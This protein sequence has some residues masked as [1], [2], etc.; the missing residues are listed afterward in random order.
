MK[1]S[2]VLE[3]SDGQRVHTQGSQPEAASS[4]NKTQP[5]IHESQEVELAQW[6]IR[7]DITEIIN[8]KTQKGKSKYKDETNKNTIAEREKDTMAKLTRMERRA[9]E[10]DT[11]ELPPSDMLLSW[12]YFNTDMQSTDL[13]IEDEETLE[14]IE[15]NLD[16]LVDLRPYMIVSPYVCTTTDKFQK[17][18]TT[19]RQMQLRQCCV[20]NPV[21]GSLQG[22]ISR[23][24]LFNYLSLPT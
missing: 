2:D 21:D 19:F 10:L 15:A 16:K 9:S 6:N 20:I 3:Q 24:N 23:E 13:S 1:T 5:P 4:L 18:L 8:I 17:V 7:D 12:R 22:V 14:M 11:A